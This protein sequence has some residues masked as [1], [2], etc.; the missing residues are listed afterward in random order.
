[1]LGIVIRASTIEG[2][3]VYG[4]ASIFRLSLARQVVERWN[5]IIMK[6]VAYKIIILWCAALSGLLA[7][8]T[9][10]ESEAL[11]SHTQQLQSYYLQ[12][13]AEVHRV[14]RRAS[15][16]DINGR[17]DAMGELSLLRGVVALE[18]RHNGEVMESIGT[19]RQDDFLMLALVP[20]NS[21]E[22]AELTIHIA[23]TELPSESSF[24]Y[25]FLLLLAILIGA[26]AATLYILVPLFHLEEKAESILTGDFDPE[27]FSPS[28]EHP[29]TSELAINLLLN[30]HHFSRQQQT[31][32]SNRLRRHSFVDSLTGL[33]NREYFDAE[34]EVHLTAEDNVTGAVGIFSFEPL[35]DCFHDDR[36][37]F[38]DL[39]VQ[40]GQ[41]FLELSNEEDLY[42]VARRG[43]TDFAWLTLENSPDKVS[44]QCYKLIKDL[45]RS[46]F[47]A[48]EFQHHFVDVGVAFFK[49]G[50][51]AYEVLASADMALR[52]A[53]LEGENKVNVF[54]PDYLT[55]DMIKG[56]VR[57]RSFLQNK[58]DRR[59]VILYFQPQINSLNDDFNS[60]EVLSRI[61]DNSKII[62]ASVFLPMASRCG[63]A[64]E[65][66]RLI[67]DTALKSL[68]FGSQ[69][70]SAE[71]SINLFSDS[72]RNEKFIHWLVQRLSS[73]PE[74][75]ER[76]YFE[77]SEFAIMNAD[78]TFA[79][80]LEQVAELGAR[81]CVESVGSPNADLSYLRRYPIDRLK[82]GHS[83]VR[84]IDQHEEKQLFVQ[85]LITAANHAGVMVWAEGVESQDE[86][87]TLANLGVTGGQGFWFG[88]PQDKLLLDDSVEVDM[89]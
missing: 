59:E 54:K 89:D 88:E 40:V 2:I 67:V 55:K 36:A 76:L 30:E 25:F 20:I 81:W 56:G 44:R 62:P 58:L 46:V 85:T 70:S 17:R 24:S 3:K 80:A 34:L 38:N 84:Q 82:I 27:H 77:V 15:F 65:F 4:I 72:V 61:E 8:S 18:L 14:L 63:L 49:S 57:W 26:I 83:I 41:R 13:Q 23:L 6:S 60:F 42:W 29:L 64:S 50:D 86:W 74:L 11:A 52:N 31:E 35:M 10:S 87:E 68:T 9:Y 69:L 5:F 75:S 16:S 71:L 1:M 33:G 28:D 32:L 39:I 66:D 22:L 53:Q 51:A 78:Q 19:V 48:T 7:L 21:A 43:D 45:A 47:D 12:Q 37:M 73:L 79:W